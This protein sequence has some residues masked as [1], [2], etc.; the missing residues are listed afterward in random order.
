MYDE[1][2]EDYEPTKADSYRKKVVLDGEEVNIKRKPPPLPSLKNS[3]VRP[4][5]KTNVH[6]Q[7][8]LMEIQLLDS[9]GKKAYPDQAYVFS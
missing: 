8:F 2:V 9:S 6:D 7:F 5:R 3:C 1:F 4:C